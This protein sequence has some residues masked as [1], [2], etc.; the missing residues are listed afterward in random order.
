MPKV[1]LK[2]SKKSKYNDINAAEVIL[3]IFDRKLQKSIV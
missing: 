3:M 1:I 2:K